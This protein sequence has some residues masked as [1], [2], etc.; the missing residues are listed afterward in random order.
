VDDIPSSYLS[1]ILDLTVKTALKFIDSDKV[2]GK[3]KLPLFRGPRCRCY[4]RCDV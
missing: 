4:Q 1:S 2:T 3:N